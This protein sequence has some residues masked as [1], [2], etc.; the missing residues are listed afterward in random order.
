MT[1]PRHPAEIDYLVEPL[2]LDDALR[3]IEAYGGSR[4]YVPKMF[5]PDCKLAQEFGDQMARSMV[6]RWGG[7]MLKVPSVRWWRILLYRR[8]GMSYAQIARKLG[9]SETTVW[10]TLNSAQ[11]TKQLQLPI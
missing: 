11:E 2:G 3:L 9:C 6:A 4:L 5:D 7:D 1:L 10:Q 8:E